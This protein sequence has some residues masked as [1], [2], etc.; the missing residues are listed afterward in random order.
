V[1]EKRLA[2][3]KQ[4]LKQ[5]EEELS[6][7][8]MEHLLRGK[9][10]DEIAARIMSNEI[11]QE[12][13]QAIKQLQYQPENISYKGIKAALRGYER[14]GYIDIEK[15]QIRI[16]SKG[17]RVLAR[18]A[19]KRALEN[20]AKGKIG[21]HPIKEIGYG[22]GVSAYSKRY[23]LGD[24]YELVDIEKPLLNSLERNRR[25]KL[26]TEDF[27][28]FQTVHQTRVC[29]G[30]L[31]DESGSMQRDHKIKAAI[32]ASLALSELITREPKDQLLV[33][34]FSESVNQIQP[35]DIVNS[36]VG[37]GSTD[38]RAAMRVFRKV[39]MNKRGDKQAY[40]ITDTEPNTEDGVYGGGD[41]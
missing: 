38:I 37:D 13:E 19:L 12:L 32:E 4:E 40:L 39:T 41:N 6:Y 27:Q 20:L 25:F 34:I 26:E 11:R 3:Y 10:V 29:A 5:Y 14:Q 22:S 8:V 7:E 2:E 21:S 36:V 15:E 31:I 28:V 1:W 18:Q 9:D 17:S 33:F 30:L 23:E 16:T 35:W 24:A